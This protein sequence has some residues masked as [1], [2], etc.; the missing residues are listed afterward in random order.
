[1][2]SMQRCMSLLTPQTLLDMSLAPFSVARDFQRQLSAMLSNATYAK[3]F[4]TSTDAGT[5]LWFLLLLLLL[6]LQ[7][8]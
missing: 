8:A 5:L 7:C 4:C 2:F 3:Y 6:L 1:M